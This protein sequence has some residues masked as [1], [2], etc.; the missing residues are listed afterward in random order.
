MMFEGAFL[1]HEPN[2]ENVADDS[3]DGL[4][5]FDEFR[6]VVDGLGIH[7]QDWELDGHYL[8]A[9]EPLL[10]FYDIWK[11]GPSRKEL[12]KFANVLSTQNQ[13]TQ[14]IIHEWS[15]PKCLTTDVATS[16]CTHLCFK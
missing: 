5:D 7:E 15:V 13:S 14:N 4:L 6:S 2:R 8:A 9:S 10:H 12:V 11:H 1:F 3:G 16:G